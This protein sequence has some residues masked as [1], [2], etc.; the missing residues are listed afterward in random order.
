MAT[1]SARWCDVGMGTPRTAVGRYRVIRFITA[2]AVVGVAATACPPPTPPAPQAPVVATFEALGAPHVAPALVPLR[3]TV[4]DPQNDP[5]TCRLDGDGDGVWDETFEPCPLAASR[6]ASDVLA[7]SHTGRLEVSDGSNS[8]VATTT[9]T[10]APP[11]T[12]E[13]F[14]IVVRVAGPMDADVVAAFESAAARWEV[15]IVAGVSDLAV[16]VPAGSCGS[17]STALDEVV[18]DLVVNV[19]MQSTWPVAAMAWACLLGPDNL[20]RVG[21]VD[22]DPDILQNLRTLDV[23]D[24]VAL[25]ELG[26]VL[27]FG[28]VGQFYGL[29]VGSGTDDPRFTGPRALAEASAL[30]R[31]GGIPISTV[32]GVVQ[33]HWEGALLGAEI[34]A[35]VPDGSALSRLTIAAL[36]DLGYSVDLDA[37]D[38]YTPELPPNTCV[39]F[40]D[41]VVRCW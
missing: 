39:T 29:I 31:A 8:T 41:T 4:S 15:A 34:M 22:V 14:D 21:H 16:S 30:G 7:G 12:S 25:H 17:N 23:V 28:I 10:V 36:G 38:P 19:S 5:L 1:T 27:G 32:D 11:T 2:L 9:Y 26:H 20:P 37:A 18:D 24:E 6:N 40:S 3:W 35:L 33:P 13:A